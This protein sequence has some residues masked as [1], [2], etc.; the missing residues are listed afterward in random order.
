M[1]CGSII[2]ALILLSLAA[3]AR[4]QLLGLPVWNDPNTGTGITLSGDVGFPDADGFGTVYAGR[5]N[6]GVGGLQ[7]GVTAGTHEP[8][9]SDRVSSLG[10]SLGVRL[11]GGTVLPF[12]INAQGGF[13]TED[14]DVGR[15]T[16]ATAS[17]GLGVSTPVPGMALQ[18]WLSPGVRFLRHPSGGVDGRET[19]TNFGAAVGASLGMGIVGIHVGVDYENAAGDLSET[20]VGVGVHIGFKAPVGM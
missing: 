18:A 3:P 15:F 20:T 1:R 8:E 9:G 7:I 4:A 11:I 10:G 14:S 2:A 16:R 19:D 5:A 6:L 13:S 17:I 12:A